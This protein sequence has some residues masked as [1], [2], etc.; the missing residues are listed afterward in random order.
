MSKLFPITSLAAV[1]ALAVAL[2]GCGGGGDSSGASV[3]QSPGNTSTVAQ[4]ASPSASVKASNLATI[5][6]DSGLAG[7]PNMPFVSVT[8]CR[9]GTA[10][11]RTIDHVLVDTG[12][13]GLR[14][15]ASQL[16]ASVALPQQTDA[17]AQ[18]VA[19]C[20][21]FFDGYTWGPVRLADVRIAGETAHGLPIQVIDPGYASI[22]T[23]CANVGPAKNTPA[24][25]AAN[26]ILGIGVFLHDC[27][28]NCAA[29]AIA[30]TYYTCT[31]GTCISSKMPEALQVAN[32]IPYFETN[33]NGV[34]VQLPT[35]S[36]GGAPST[37]GS[38]IFGIGTQPNNAL[39]GARVLPVSA[40]SGRFTTVFNGTAYSSS[41]I[42]SGSTALFFSTDA[43]P[44]CADPNPAY[45]CPTSLATLNATAQGADGSTDTI[46]FTVANA[47]S[48]S[49]QGP[50][51]A[52][53][54]SLAGNAFVNS[55]VFDWG[56][57]FFYGK[58]VYAAIET[59]TT[60]G[61][62]GPYF[63]Y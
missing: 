56:L 9:P 19:E 54:P 16:P 62:N 34:I 41:L 25:L 44:A 2:N 21:Q 24:T 15:F 6:I 57:P 18:P 43:L 61:G 38:L 48:L 13:W 40:T 4:T 33:N 28:A 5:T 29:Q 36:P 20:M 46:S 32:P 12:S 53:L 37:T 8:V 52:A 45:Y 1:F 30:A 26:G 51:Y 23:D 11:C 50:G 27:G 42:D 14:V 17:N 3:A 60:A 59:K 47:N 49:A 10:D 39:A 58:S 63:A 22:P 55:A 31:G 7:I 35:V